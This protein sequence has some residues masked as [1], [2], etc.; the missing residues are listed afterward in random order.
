MQR[1]AAE[2]QGVSLVAPLQ[3]G[4]AQGHRHLARRIGA[5]KQSDGVA[6]GIP[7]TVS[8]LA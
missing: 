8:G 3:C 5:A 6:D 7:A 4:P 1:G 2:I